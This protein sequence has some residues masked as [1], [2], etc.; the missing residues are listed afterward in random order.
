MIFALLYDAITRMTR[1]AIYVVM[2]DPRYLNLLRASVE[3]LKRVMPE[4]PVTVFSQFPVEGLHFSEVRKVEPAGDGFYDKARLMLE[5]PYEQTVFIDTDIYAVQRFDELFALL[6]RFDF[7]ATHEEYL[8]TDWF[9]HYPRPDIPASYPEF[10]TGIL[11]Y[12]RSTSMDQLLVTWSELYK[13]FLEENPGK[14]TN[15]Q[16][17]FRAAA[18]YSEARAAT[19]GREYNCK[20]RGQGYLNGPA[21]LLHGHVKFKMKP[22]YMRRVAAVMNASVKPRVY[23]GGKVFDQKISGRLWGKRK[24][25]KVGSFPEPESVT[26]LRIKKLKELIN[27]RGL[28][29]VIRR[30]PAPNGASAVT[31]PQT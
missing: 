2:H 16:P 5:S 28:A 24:A 1:G 29:A 20:F 8:N 31:R 30:F 22:E 7:A 12:R 4:L 25:H 14:A 3:S 23:I 13:K 6:D 19:L 26:M 15:D 27:Q 11:A 21:K 18:Y 9:S 10:N 17:F